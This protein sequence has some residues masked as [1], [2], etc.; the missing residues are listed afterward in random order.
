MAE[1][2]D[3]R[4]PSADLADGVA[5]LVDVACEAEAAH[6]G[7]QETR[8]LALLAGEAGDAQHTLEECDRVEIG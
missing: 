1:Q 4:W 3:R 5:S 2:H 6:L 7:H 8:Q